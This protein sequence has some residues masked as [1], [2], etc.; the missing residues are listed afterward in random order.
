MAEDCVRA[1]PVTIVDL[2]SN[3]IILRQTT[4]YIPIRELQRLAAT[5]TALRNLIYHSPLAWHYLNLSTVKRA[6]IDSSPIDVGGFSWRA[7]RMDESLTEDDFYAGP[8]RGIFSKLRLRRV[9]GNVQSLVLD[10]L[11]VPA[12][13]IREIMSEDQY[14]VRIL[15]IREVKNL[16]PAKLQ[17][18]LRYV[19][20]PTRAEGTPTLNALYY[21]GPKD[22]PKPTT[23]SRSKLTSGRELGVMGSP[24]AQIGAEWNEKS[25]HTLSTT[26]CDE[27][28]KWYGRTGRA[29]KRP[30]SDW[31]DTLTV[32][33]GIINFDAV[34]CRGPKHN[35]NLVDS[36]DFLQPTI[37]TVALG[38]GCESCGSSPEGEAMFGESDDSALPLLG[39]VPCH[40]TATRA[41]LRPDRR[42]DSGSPKLFVRCEECLRGRWCEQC[43]RWWCETC[44]QEP[45]SREHLRT[46]M[47]QIELRDELQRNGWATVTHGPS[48]QAV[49]VYSKMCTEYCLLQSIEMIS[50]G[51]WG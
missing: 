5:C 35:I 48:N 44:Y 18:V 9:L 7:E 50:D 27:E 25:T 2:L 42:A 8:L 28:S 17:Q 15:S 41:A 38:S 26:L 22:A 37:A 14:R 6:V 29:I 39:P 47:Q 3:S 24:G 16:N 20:R 51:M 36:K 19:C 13:L 11:S 34:L 45:V 21:F 23:Q 30:Q 10:G 46:D 40:S 32:C 43:N 12:D 49:K 31:A 33:K 1:L 4:P